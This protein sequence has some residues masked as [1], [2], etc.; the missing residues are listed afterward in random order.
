MFLVQKILVC[1]KIL[2]MAFILTEASEIGVR[3][4]RS[5]LF[6]IFLS[7]VFEQGHKTQCELKISP[8]GFYFFQFILAQLHR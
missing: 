8:P 6:K 4:S 5:E 2:I 1:K 3:F 7:Q